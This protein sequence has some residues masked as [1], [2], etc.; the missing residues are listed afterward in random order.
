[1]E[2][3]VR[4]VLDPSRM[5]RDLEVFVPDGHE[6]RKLLDRLLDAVKKKLGT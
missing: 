6:G 2:A 4:P 3:V 1:V 5:E